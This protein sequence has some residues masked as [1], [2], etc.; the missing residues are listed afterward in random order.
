MTKKPTI[1]SLSEKVKELKDTLQELQSAID[2]SLAPLDHG[3][4]SRF[5]TAYTKE[6]KY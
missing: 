4:T 1:K 2:K 5:G 6:R 3:E